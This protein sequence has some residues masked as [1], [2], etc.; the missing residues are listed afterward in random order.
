MAPSKL[1]FDAQD[2]ND[3]VCVKFVRSY[4]MGAHQWC[5]EMGFAPQLRGFE[6][7][8]GGWFMVVMDKLGDEYKAF[9]FLQNNPPGMREPLEKCL[10][11]LH[12]AGL[13]ARRRTRYKCYGQ[14]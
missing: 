4:S 2:A 13:R 7:L 1:L 10:I 3:Q 6:R 9:D 11:G 5:G 14:G 8:P 12:Q